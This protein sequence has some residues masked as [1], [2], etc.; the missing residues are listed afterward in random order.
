MSPVKVNI[1]L[2]RTFVF[3]EIF[4]VTIQTHAIACMAW[5]VFS[6]STS[7]YPSK[8]ALIVWL[9]ERISSLFC[10]ALTYNVLWYFSVFQQQDADLIMLALATHEVHFSILREVSV[11]YT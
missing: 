3:R 11:L 4:L 7:V 2:C 1:K 8:D 5:Y 10:Y 6:F 9:Y